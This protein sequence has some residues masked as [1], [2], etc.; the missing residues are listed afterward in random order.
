MDK[1]C[2]VKFQI[3]NEQFFFVMKITEVV[4]SKNIEIFQDKNLGV[5]DYQFLK[6]KLERGE[7]EWVDLRVNFLVFK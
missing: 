7:I 6:S 1:F 5:E 2:L 3:T 4:F